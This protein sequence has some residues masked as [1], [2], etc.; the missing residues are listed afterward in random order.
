MSVQ[1]IN[2]ETFAKPLAAY[3]QVTHKGSVVT[4]AGA[5]LADEH[6]L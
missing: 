3:C 6:C 5:S 4:T 2:P 1:R